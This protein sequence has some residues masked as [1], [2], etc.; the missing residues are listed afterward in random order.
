MGEFHPY[1]VTV[2]ATGEHEMIAACLPDD[3]PT[4]ANVIT[5]LTSTPIDVPGRTS[6]LRHAGRCHARP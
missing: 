3:R 1:A 6:R 5:A 2:D 4:S